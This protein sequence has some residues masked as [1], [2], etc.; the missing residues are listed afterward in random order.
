MALP[1]D[2]PGEKE[3]EKSTLSMVTSQLM[4]ISPVDKFTDK[5]GLLSVCQS[6]KVVPAGMPTP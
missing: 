1:G 5:Q 6:I 2:E 3:S 4:V